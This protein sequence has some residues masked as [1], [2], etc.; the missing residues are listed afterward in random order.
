MK[1]LFTGGGTAGHVTPN[2]AIIDSIDKN[3]HEIIYVGRT[4]GI[5]KDLVS[6][7]GI[8]YFGLASGKMRRYLSFENVKDFF[9]V[10]KGIFQANKIM[11]EQKPDVIFSKGGFVAVPV[12][13]AGAIN[14]VPVVC[15]ESDITPGLTTK[16]SAWFA[17]KICVSFP[18]TI[19]H[20]IPDKCVVTGTPIRDE[21][22][23]GSR[24]RGLELC[25]FN[26]EKPVVLVI[27]GSTGSKVINMVVREA[28]EELI[29]D[30]QIIHICGK[31]NIDERFNEV[32]EY[33]QFG[34]VKEELADLYSAA[35]IIVSRAGANVIFEILN[36][37]K[38]NI[39][40]PLSKKVS[41][42]DQIQN[43]VFF[44][45]KG[46]SRMLREERFNDYTLINDISEVLERKEMYLENIEK[47]ELK[48]SKEL[49]I[50]EILAT[51]K[52]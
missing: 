38:L 47:S 14:K 46:Y 3:E 25:G 4:E 12:V 29:K 37:K 6:Q 45:V 21:V 8:E 43:A 20:F 19:R 15:H 31:D 9:R 49:I 16:I 41:R 39:L 40:V 48:N 33:K 17:R 23:N 5:E 2:L 28:L 52:V 24:E 51:A 27:G 34:Y 7:K 11:K 42:G 22:L 50:K 18:D 10:I 35:D 44:E 30:Y 32:E 13:I 1:I 26:N 36:L